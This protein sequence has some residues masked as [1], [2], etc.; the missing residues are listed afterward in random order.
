MRRSPFYQ[1]DRTKFSKN[2]SRRDMA[3]KTSSPKDA[4][5]LSSGEDEEF[6][7]GANYSSEDDD[8]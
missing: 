7:I 6:G 4:R 1:R 8:N 5:S 3:S 2:P